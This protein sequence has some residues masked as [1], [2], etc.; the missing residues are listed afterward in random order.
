MENT[1]DKAKIIWGTLSKVNCN[2]KV[3]QKN[4][5]NYLPWAWAWGIAMEYFP[6]AEYNIKRWNEKPYLVDELLGILVETSVTIDGLTR[7]MFLPVMD[8]SNKAQRLVQYTYKTKFGEKTVEPATMFDVNTAIM[9]CLVK[10]LA[11]FGLGHYIYA[12]EDLPNT[13]ESEKPQEYLLPGSETDT[14]LV[15][16]YEKIT[17]IDHQNLP[18][19][20]DLLKDISKES[21][22]VKKFFNNWCLSKA[23]KF[24]VA[25]K[26]YEPIGI[27]IS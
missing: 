27:A 15:S 9:R 5:L 22:P 7:S 13:L 21:E 10:N 8:G 20:N 3:E 17:K 2:E 24:D 25:T 19:A 1:V 12:G 6:T 4:G 16:L 18:L 14:I 11:M 26:Q 23:M